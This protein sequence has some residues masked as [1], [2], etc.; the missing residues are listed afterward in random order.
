[1]ITTAVLLHSYQRLITFDVFVSF[2]YPRNTMKLLTSLADIQHNI[3][4]FDVQKNQQKH[5]LQYYI[6]HGIRIHIIEIHHCNATEV[7]IR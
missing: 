3:Y 1:M 4:G 7:S 5:I 6:F 2:Y